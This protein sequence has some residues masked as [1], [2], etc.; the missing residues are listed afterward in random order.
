M[1]VTLGS[2]GCLWVDFLRKVRLHK[3][4]EKTL[5]KRRVF[6]ALA[7]SGQPRWCHLRVQ[8]GQLEL[9]GLQND[10]QRGSGQAKWPQT[11][12]GE[13][14]RTAKVTMSEKS[15]CR[16]YGNQRKSA[17]TS[18]NQRKSTEI[19]A[20]QRKPAETSRNS[21]EGGGKNYRGGRTYD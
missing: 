19:S 5:V 4:Y 21:N 11:G 1:G 2:C 13:G 7:R 20:N 8:G 18:G 14:V 16:S 6:R 9:L 10:V 17:Q 12:P 15:V 3:M